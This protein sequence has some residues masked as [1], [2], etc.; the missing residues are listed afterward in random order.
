MKRIKIKINQ[1]GLL[2]RDEV[3]ERVLTTG[4]YWVGFWDEV[5]IYDM[6]YA[7]APKQELKTL[8]QNVELASLLT[9]LDLLDNEI[10]LLYKDG[11]YN[12]LLTTGMFAFWKGVPEITYQKFD[13]R[14][15]YV[16]ESIDRNLI[17]KGI[18]ARYI[19]MVRLE[20]YE[21]GVLFV[22]GNMERMLDAGTYYFWANNSTITSL[23]TDTRQLSIDIAGQEVLTKDKAQLRINCT[24][25]YKVTDVEK[26]LVENKDFDKQLYI[27]M[28]MALREFVGKLTF[29]ELMESK[30]QIA[31]NVMKNTQVKAEELGVQLAD[32]GV[33]DIIL[34]GDI[35]DIMNQVLIA[36]K[37]AQANVIMRREETASTRSL[38]NTAKLM[39]ENTML[40]KLKEMEY[41]EKIAEKINTISVSGGGQIIDQLKTLFVR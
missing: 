16:D 12:Q 28:Q 15:L 11:R 32:F 20:A 27:Q 35:K 37:R 25:Q 8:L 10:A 41:V 31:E 33:K 3:L 21:K 40:F 9:I 18:L 26:A 5:D 34:P 7:F 19:R 6:N 2:F 39:E 36:E 23:K 24:V 22:N 14:A 38:L 1:I 4:Q 30:E 29:D 13:T 17:E